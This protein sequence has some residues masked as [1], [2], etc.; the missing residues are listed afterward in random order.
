MHL[1]EMPSLEKPAS[2]LHP[3]FQRLYK[4][5]N[6]HCKAGRIFSWGTEIKPGVHIYDSYYGD[7]RRIYSELVTAV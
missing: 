7:G 6:P 5:F 3:N 2:L 1:K 4:R